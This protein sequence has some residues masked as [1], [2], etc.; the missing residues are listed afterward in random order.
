MRLL[1]AGGAGPRVRPGASAA[2]HPRGRQ[3][4]HLHAQ[5][6]PDRGDVLRGQHGG[7]HRQHGAPAV[8]RGRDRVL[9]KRFRVRRGADAGP[10]LRQVRQH[11]QEHAVSEASDHRRRGG[12]AQPADAHRLQTDRRAQDPEGAEGR[13]RDPVE[14]VH[15]RRPGVHRR[16]PGEARKRRP[17]RDP[18]LRR[19]HRHHQGHTAVQPEL[20]RAGG[21]DHRHQ[22]HSQ[23]RRQDAG[24]DAHVPRLR[25]GRVRPL[26][27]RQRRGLHTGAPL[28]APDLSG[29]AAQ[30]P[31]EPDRRRAHAVRGAFAHPQPGEPGPLLPQGR[32]LRRRTTA[33]RSRSA[34]ATAPPSASPPPA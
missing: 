19:H 13:R 11:P 25:A 28:H 6:P 7:R 5:R 20:Q 1:Q 21:A 34:R 2:R 26:D 18:L 24:P 4:D 29:A 8:R 32:F 16:P 30:V 17:R 3:G 22:P 27:A 15:R 33:R 10:V 31:A 14:A 12:R 23:G 9:L